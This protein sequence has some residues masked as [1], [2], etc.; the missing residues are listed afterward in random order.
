[1]LLLSRSIQHLFWQKPSLCTY[2]YVRL[3]EFSL[4]LFCAIVMCWN[5]IKEKAICRFFFLIYYKQIPFAKFVKN[6]FRHII[7]T[8]KILFLL[9]SLPFSNCASSSSSI[10]GSINQPSRLDRFC[11]LK[12]CKTIFN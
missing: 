6:K 3:N 1:M 2:S 7:T 8:T 12:K 11:T 10:A 4:L 5:R 9:F